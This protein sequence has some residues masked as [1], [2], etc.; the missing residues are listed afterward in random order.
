MPKFIRNRN[1]PI[2]LLAASLCAS[3]LLMPGCGKTDERAKAIR[4]ASEKLALVTSSGQRLSAVEST[5]FAH[6]RA[7]RDQVSP[8]AKDGASKSVGAVLI[9]S[10]ATTALGLTVSQIAS[11]QSNDAVN[12]GTVVRSM[13]DLYLETAASAKAAEGHDPKAELASID[14]ETKLL[15]GQIAAVKTGQDKLKAETADLSARAKAALA[16]SKVIRQ[17]ATEMRARAVGASATVGLDVETQ[18]AATN[19]LADAA[20]R[21]AADLN[22]EV[23]LREPSI[24]MLQSQLDGLGSAKA[25][26]STAK[27]TVGK[28]SALMRDRAK[29]MRES[30]AKTAA[31]IKKVADVL[32]AA[33]NDG[34]D[35]AVRGQI[36]QI[37][38]T[39]PPAPK[40]GVESPQPDGTDPLRT[41]LLNGTGP[42]S[43]KIAEGYLDDAI[44]MVRTLPPDAATGDKNAGKLAEA[45]AVH[46]RADLL[47]MRARNLE[48][49]ATVLASLAKAE[50]ALPEAG[51]YSAKLADVLKAATDALAA[52]REA[53]G[54]AQAKFGS[55]PSGNAKERFEKLALSLEKLAKG[56]I[57]AD[58][59]KIPRDGETKDAKDAKDAK[60]TKDTKGKDATPA[61][62]DPAATA[63][64]DKYLAASKAGD[65][66]AIKAMMSYSSD[67]EKRGAEA[68][69]GL[70]AQMAK[71]DAACKSKFGKTF[72]EIFKAES[73]TNP[74]L[75]MAAGMM[76]GM[77][78]AD[79]MAKATSAD[80]KAVA[81]SDTVVE[82][83]HKSE[84]TLSLGAVKADGVWKITLGG[85]MKGALSGPQAG[86]MMGLLKPMGE[87]FENAA[88][89]VNSGK[90][91]D[92]KQLVNGIMAAVMGA[93]GMPGRP[94]GG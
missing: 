90:I 24:S 84:T 88:A 53:Y 47:S 49:Y 45:A 57:P 77:G 27:E 83:V 36:E 40:A 55:A 59:V 12:Q 31:D 68:M 23:A 20:D 93:M 8:Y 10:R 76:G 44:R 66:E 13:V 37:K 67:S 89:D 3:A 38:R 60:D 41:A 48:S 61:T 86:M 33:S 35:K 2:A 62:V 51:L 1:T 65:V 26:A 54:E 75:A 39:S 58:E 91:K 78:G 81:K 34:D 16:K 42:T 74:Q 17:Q 56:D 82:F 11:E 19:R 69:L 94:G 52:A 72:A 79:A 6:L 85:A 21:E 32:M 30:Q 43:L 63:A 14:A 7:V 46:A 4:E 87:A 9:Y 50:P 29:T 28:L 5:R 73:A 71:L 92:G 64:L 70:N 22:A 80:F 15:D 18:I 25:Q